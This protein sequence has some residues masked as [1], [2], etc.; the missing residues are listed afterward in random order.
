MFFFFLLLFF[1]FLKKKK[2]KKGE[3]SILFGEKKEPYLELCMCSWI[4]FVLA[5]VCLLTETRLTRWSF[6]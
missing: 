2:E 4:H 5:K 6:Q 3:M 1:F